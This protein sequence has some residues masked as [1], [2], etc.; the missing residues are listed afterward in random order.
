MRKLCVDV[1]LEKC[2]NPIHKIDVTDIV[3]YLR[4]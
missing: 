3:T 2:L 4:I 1:L